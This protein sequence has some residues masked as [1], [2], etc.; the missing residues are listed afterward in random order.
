MSLGL[1]AHIMGTTAAPAEMVDAAGAVTNQEAL[2]TNG[3]RRTLWP[4]AT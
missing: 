2:A 4:L 1:W 3:L